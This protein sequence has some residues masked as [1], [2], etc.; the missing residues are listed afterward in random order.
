MK[1]PWQIATC[2]IIGITGPTSIHL[3]IHPPGLGNITA[4]YGKSTEQDCKALQRVVHLAERIIGSTVPCIKDIYT[5]RC[6]IKA[7]RIIKDPNHMDNGLFSLLRSRR[8]YRIHQ[9]STE[10][11]RIGYFVSLKNVMSLL[12][13]MTEELTK[14]LEGKQD[15]ILGKSSNQ[16]LYQYLTGC[17]MNIGCLVYSIRDSSSC[18]L[19]N[20]AVPLNPVNPL[21]ASFLLNDCESA[22][23]R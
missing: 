20:Y 15:G 16:R 13:P 8:R 1:F 5:G 3:F 6:E 9:A 4:W 12:V 10:R 21:S 7:R 19:E 22:V 2:I 14:P 17:L 18:C 11:L 23:W